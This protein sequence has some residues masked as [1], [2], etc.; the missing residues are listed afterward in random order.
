[1]M[2]SL[3]GEGEGGIFRIFSTG[4][5]LRLFCNFQIFITTKNGN[6][7]LSDDIHSLKTYVNNIVQIS[8]KIKCQCSFISR[9]I[10]IIHLAS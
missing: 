7:A 1:M 4:A 9:N 2:H 6:I 5:I 10:L 8:A 3:A